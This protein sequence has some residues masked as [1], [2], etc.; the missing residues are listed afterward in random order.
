MTVMHPVSATPDFH[1]MSVPVPTFT[2]AVIFSALKVP[3]TVFSI[4]R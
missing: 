3:I 2:A 1:S 4:S